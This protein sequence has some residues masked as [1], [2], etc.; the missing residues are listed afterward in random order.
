MTIILTIIIT[1]VVCQLILSLLAYNGI[2]YGEEEYLG[3]LCGIWCI[4]FL[5][6]DRIRN[7]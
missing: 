5:I 7:K 1:V 2:I 3:F 6:Y 4:V